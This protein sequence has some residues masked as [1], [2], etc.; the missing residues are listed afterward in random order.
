MLPHGYT[1]NTDH[2]SPLDHPWSDQGPYWNL[3]GNGGI[4]STVG[5]MY[6]WRQALQGGAV[7]S[8]AAREKL[9]T[10]FRQNYACGWD[11]RQT[12]H[13]RR[14]GH[15]GASD[16]GFNAIIGWYEEGGTTVIALCNSGT[17]EGSG[18]MSQVLAF[19]M[20]QL[21]FGGAVP[22]FPMSPRLGLSRETL[23]NYEGLYELPS[24]S[25]VRVGLRD[26]HMVMEPSG[27]DAVALLALAPEDVVQFEALDK[28]AGLIVQALLRGDY[29]PLQEAARNEQA[30]KAY[31]QILNKRF[32]EWEKTD[33]PIER[34]FVVGTVNS[35][36][37]GAGTP[38]SFIQVVLK[39]RRRLFR[40]HW[41][42][43]KIAGI[44][45][46]AIANPIAIPLRATKPGEFSGWHFA[47]AKPAT[48]RFQQSADGRFTEAIFC[49]EGQTLVG[50]KQRK[51]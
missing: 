31:S 12:S 25:T 36:W 35:W 39:N 10:P 22:S 7:L 29:G 4:L 23:K 5:D 43:G 19:R 46:S 11:V 27:Q 1:G 32:R 16:M 9:F 8:A 44:G 37:D 17:Y 45:G 40:L 38:V 26:D 50:R 33:G 2:G 18:E 48:V 42:D 24:T 3:L 34:A 20:I 28:R 47:M 21:A 49:V 13:G 41:Q 30:G 15:N 6:L 51:P 14:I